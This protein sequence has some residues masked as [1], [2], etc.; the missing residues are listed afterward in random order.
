MSMKLH[1][2][3]LSIGLLLF[4]TKTKASF[5]V[6]DSIP[7]NY[8]WHTLKTPGVAIQMLTKDILTTPG[9]K[10]LAKETMSCLTPLV[11]LLKDY[12]QHV[13][14][15]TLFAAAGDNRLNEQKFELI[16][17]FLRKNGIPKRRIQAHNHVRSRGPVPIFEGKEYPLDMT[18]DKKAAEAIDNIEIMFADK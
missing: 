9:G 1:H 4:N 16:Y 8:Q 13:V 7:C 12:R 17:Q 11:R 15:V 5:G 14:W 18:I 10:K 3:F 2:I 6:A